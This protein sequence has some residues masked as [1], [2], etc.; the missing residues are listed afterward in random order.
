MSYLLLSAE[1]YSGEGSYFWYI[2]AAIVVMLIIGNALNHTDE[3]VDK[4]LDKYVDDVGRNYTHKSATPSPDEWKD[5][6]EYKYPRM[7]G[8][9]WTDGFDKK[10]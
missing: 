1:P 10:R 8:N 2:F 9:E 4:D 3:S 7:D 5:I 6:R